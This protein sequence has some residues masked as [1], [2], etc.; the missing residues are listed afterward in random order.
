LS[1][2]FFES[3]GENMENARIHHDSSCLLGYTVDCQIH[4]GITRLPIRAALYGSHQKFGWE[5]LHCQGIGGGKY[6]VTFLI[7]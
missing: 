4:Q 7:C 6:Q 5:I 2:A 1:V 3:T